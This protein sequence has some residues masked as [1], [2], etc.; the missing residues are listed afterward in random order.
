MFIFFSTF[1]FVLP[2]YLLSL[3]SFVSELIQ[4]GTRFSKVTHADTVTLPK[5]HHRC[6]HRCMVGICTRASSPLR[7]SYGN[8]RKLY[9]ATLPHD[10]SCGF[11]LPSSTTQMIA[12]GQG[13]ISM[14]F[15]IRPQRNWLTSNRCRPCR[16]NN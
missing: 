16:H 13:C 3:R 14:K 9:T 15:H 6:D 2:W 10:L 11:K 5:L 8:D 1:Q 4:L 7:P 12:M